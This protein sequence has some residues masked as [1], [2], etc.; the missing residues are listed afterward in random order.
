MAQ[1]HIHYF[2]ELLFTCACDFMHCKTHRHAQMHGE[3]V[4][5]FDGW[6]EKKQRRGEGRIDGEERADG[7]GVGQGWR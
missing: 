1:T 4:S 7:G 3:I 2:V 6:K 5:E